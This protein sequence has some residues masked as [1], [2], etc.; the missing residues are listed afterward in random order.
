LALVAFS[1]L[2]AC[3]TRHGTAGQT[4][5]GSTTSGGS[6]PPPTAT[7][8][9][10]HTTNQVFAW[11]SPSK[12]GPAC[13]AQC[14]ARPQ[15]TGIDNISTLDAA[16]EFNIAI[17]THGLLAWG[18]NHGRELG[19]A[20]QQASP[21]AGVLVPGLGRVIQTATGNKFTIA[22]LA[23]GT[24]KAW[25]LNLE[26]QFGNGSSKSSAA[27]VAVPGLSG[28]KQVAAGGNHALALLSNGQVMAWGANDHG[29]LGDGSTN[30]SLRPVH[31]KGLTDA[32]AISSGNLFSA[33]LLRNG[34]VMEWGDDQWGQLGNGREAKVVSTPVLVTGLQNVVQVS[35]GGNVPA[36]GHTLALLKDGTVVAWGSNKFGQLGNNSTSD[37]AVPVPV[38]GLK[39]VKQVAAGGAHS[40]AL[41][42]N[43]SVWCWG[44]NAQGQ[45]GD[46]TFTNRLVPVEVMT[47]ASLISAGSQHSLAVVGRII[48]L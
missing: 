32:I 48:P 3:S 38:V 40:M 21:N 30:N 46:G 35:A 11:G 15:G 4:S 34:T 26:G 6:S 10:I 28:V 17:T 18:Q 39:N 47:G 13:S 14:A 20:A 1:M 42:D 16:N 25:G 9:S 36:D 41:L 44:S 19:P 7:S 27:P 5:N 45:I 33:A 37:S 8:P 43:G 24:V 29:Q 23:G 22:L 12:G 31:V 2:A